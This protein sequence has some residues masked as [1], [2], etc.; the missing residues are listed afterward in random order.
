MQLSATWVT[1]YFVTT[2]QLCLLLFKE[3]H[4]K[5]LY[6]NEYS[7]FNILL[8]LGHEVPV[9][10]FGDKVR[11]YKIEKPIFYAQN[12][13]VRKENFIQCQLR[14]KTSGLKAHFFQQYLICDA[15]S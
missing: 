8:Y 11:H 9:S 2:C 4:D 13:F 10:D 15:A 5:S 3:I 12:N 7:Y 6:D 1:D 14:K